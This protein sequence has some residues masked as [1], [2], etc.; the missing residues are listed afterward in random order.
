M[1]VSIKIIFDTTATLMKIPMTSDEDT[2]SL[3]LSSSVAAQSDALPEQL[4]QRPRKKSKLARSG[5]GSTS[6]TVRPP[7]AHRV[8]HDA[9]IMMAMDIF[10]ISQDS[11]HSVRPTEV[12]FGNMWDAMKKMHE[13]W[14]IEGST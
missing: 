3:L 1:N 8:S 6:A 13:H 7:T 11:I 10:L 14:V 5:N 2:A 9:T 4:K 12:E